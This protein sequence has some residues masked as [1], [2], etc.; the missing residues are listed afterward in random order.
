[1]KQITNIEIKQKPGEGN[2]GINYSFELLDRQGDV[3]LY[4]FVYTSE[5]EEEPSAVTV[6][7]RIPSVNVF[8]TWNPEV[9]FERALRTVCTAGILNHSRIC[10]SAPVQTLIGQDGTNA[11]TVA[12]SDAVL[13]LTINTQIYEEGMDVLCQITFFSLPVKK[14]N[15]YEAVVRLDFREVPYYEAITDVEKWWSRDLGMEAAKVPEAAKEALYSTWY[16]YHHDITEESVVEQWR[17][18]V[19]MGM[20]TV[21]LDAGWQMKSEAEP[22]YGDWRAYNPAVNGLVPMVDAIHELGMKFVLWFSIPFISK[23]AE[24]WNRFGEYVLDNTANRRWYCLDPRYPEVRE[25]LL[26]IYENAVKEWKLD[27]LKLDFVNSFELG[28]SAKRPDDRRDY[29]SLEEAVDRLLTDIAKRLRSIKEDI[30]LEFRQPYIGPK[31]RMTGNM[32]RVNDC[33]NDALFNRVGVIDLRL[34]SGQS[35]VHSDM[36]RWNKEEPPQGCARQ[37]IAVLFSVPQISVKIEEQNK[38][39]R[40]TLQF[41]LNFWNANRD[42][43]LD[44]ELIPLNPELN[45]GVVEAR[46][47]E[48][49]ITVC[50][51]KNYIK[52]DQSR[53]E[54]IIVNGCGEE[55]IILDY[56]G[57]E[58]A[59]ELTIYD[60]MGNLVRKDVCT[61]KRGLNGFAV[62]ECG[63]IVVENR[64]CR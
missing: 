17:R 33:P 23:D 64:D 24:S 12:V 13:P 60:C 6:Q 57:K 27:G 11:F 18:A 52:S 19:E 22:C 63:M 32:L 20:K 42:V 59:A 9:R 56:S 40:A 5:R 45:Y 58:Y 37:L 26:H 48:K 43:L 54:H 41:Y 16:S 46:R 36:I 4:R 10:H 38:E 8:S 53:K 30:L 15:H 50:Y 47:E 21:I 31:A 62:P 49:A 14:M 28:D 2:D 3:L 7:W 1:M 55:V 39:Q 29:E 25:Y 34:L 35:V 61:V 51:G 44:G